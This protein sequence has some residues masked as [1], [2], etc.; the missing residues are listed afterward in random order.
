MA[1]LRDVAVNT[2]LAMILA[3]GEDKSALHDA[4]GLVKPPLALGIAAVRGEEVS[5]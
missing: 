3:E 4:I 2:P 5:T 1:G